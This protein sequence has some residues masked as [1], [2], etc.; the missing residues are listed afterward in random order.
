MEIE[1]V[2]TANLQG[3]SRSAGEELLS[4]TDAAVSA[5]TGTDKSAIHSSFVNADKY[6][7]SQPPYHMQPVAMDSFSAVFSP[8]QPNRSSQHNFET[9][10]YC[11]RLKLRK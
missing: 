5:L 9:R 3:F 6:D 4:L 2:Q 8:N 11:K 1:L 10:V 7:A